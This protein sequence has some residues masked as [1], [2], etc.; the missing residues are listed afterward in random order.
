MER[1]HYNEFFLKYVLSIS[2]PALFGAVLSWRDHQVRIPLFEGDTCS[3]APNQAP[4]P[5]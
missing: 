2:S 5:I 1:R 4:Q 3:D